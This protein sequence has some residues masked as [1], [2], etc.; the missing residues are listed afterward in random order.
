MRGR[1]ARMLACGRECVCMCAV[2][3][4]HRRYSSVNL[5]VHELASRA[6][7]TCWHRA[8]AAISVHRVCCPV[9]GITRTVKLYSLS[10]NA[11]SSSVPSPR[12]VLTHAHTRTG[13]CSMRAPPA[14]RHSRS[15]YE[16]LVRYLDSCVSARA[17]DSA[18]GVACFRARAV[19]PDK[20]HTHTR[21]FP[22]VAPLQSPK[23]VRKRSA[24]GR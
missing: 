12:R 18:C 16:L 5:A 11:H 9:H 6:G 10:R 13:S 21:R 22:V 3:E 14:P 20:E 24:A 15:L 17:P 4:P 1:G 23:M 2:H 19:S 7:I 8:A